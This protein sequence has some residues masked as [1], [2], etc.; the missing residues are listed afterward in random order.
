MGTYIAKLNGKQF[1][2]L[3]NHQ[4]ILLRKNALEKDGTILERPEYIQKTEEF[5]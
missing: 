3:V 4:V 5:E 2:Q 1:I